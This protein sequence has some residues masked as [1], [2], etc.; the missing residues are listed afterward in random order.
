MSPNAWLAALVALPLA[1]TLALWTTSKGSA[2]L[3]HGIAFTASLL[4]LCIALFLW[5]AYPLKPVISLGEGMMGLSLRQTWFHLGSVPV[6]IHLGLDGFNLP[7][8]LLTTFLSVIGILGTWNLE[9]SYTRG[10]F[11]GLLL[12]QAGLLGLFLSLDLMLFFFFWESLLLP[13]FFLLGRWGGRYRARPLIKSLLIPWSGSLFLLFAILFLGVQFN[14]FSLPKLYQESLVP[15]YQ[16]LLF[17]SFG[18]AFAIRTPLFPLHTWMADAHTESP[19]AASMLLT[20]V[21][22]SVGVYGF[23]RI[24]LPLFPHAWSKLQQPIMVVAVFGVVYGVF[25]ALVQVDLKKQIAYASISHLGVIV[26]GAF[27]LNIQGL[28]GSLLHLVSHGVAVGGLFLVIGFLEQRRHTRTLSEYGGLAQVTP[29][30]S[31]FTLLFLLSLIGIPGLSGFVGEFLIVLGMFGTNKVY[32]T[33]A[34]LSLLGLSIVLIWTYRRYF[35]GGL[36]RAENYH[37]K[38]IGRRET[39]TLMACALV[40]LGLG[41]FPSLLLKTTTHASQSLIRHVQERAPRKPFVQ[42][43]SSQKQIASQVEPTRRF[44]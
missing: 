19:T 28:Q 22:L 8:I 17:A 7:L 30:M 9:R 35:L 36:T 1:G 3:H 5:L 11:S 18:L 14:T 13:T 43:S 40:L 31:L 41:L 6:H 29:R 34:L 32:A 44:R 2:K 25:L 26:L 12:L 20:G 39:L 42:K 15:G 37:M 10:Y 23:L 21:T 4:N 16:Y 27:S 33:L 24:G 38:D